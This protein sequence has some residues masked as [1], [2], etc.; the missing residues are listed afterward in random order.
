MFICSPGRDSWSF[1][2]ILYC[3]SDPTVIQPEQY[4]MVNFANAAVLRFRQ[5]TVAII[6]ISHNEVTDDG[7]I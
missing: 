3:P 6:K 2:S 7:R 5:G 1:L 4:G